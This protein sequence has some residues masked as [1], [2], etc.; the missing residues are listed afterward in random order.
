MK[1]QYSTVGLLHCFG[2][3]TFLCLHFNC[4]LCFWVLYTISQQLLLSETHNSLTFGTQRAALPCSESVWL[5]VLP[6]ISTNR[7]ETCL[8]LRGET[9]RAVGVE[10]R[11]LKVRPSTTDCNGT[12]TAAVCQQLCWQRSADFFLSISFVVSNIFLPKLIG[13]FK[14]L[15]DKSDFQKNRRK[16]FW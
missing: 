6:T 7:C 2:T 10:T 4:F 14:D 8:S 16:E 5:D 12:A 13:T 3:L 1:W 15:S 9:I 11:M